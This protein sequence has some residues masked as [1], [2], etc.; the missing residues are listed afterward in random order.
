MIK[1]SI[2]VY[3]FTCWFMEFDEFVNPYNKTLICP[4]CKKKIT[5]ADCLVLNN[6]KMF[7]NIRCHKE[8]I[9]I[10]GFQKTVRFLKSDW[11]AAQKKKQEIKVWFGE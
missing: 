11:E 4:I 3:G 10:L 5:K 1:Y 2:E 8:C 6:Y 9:D 7:P